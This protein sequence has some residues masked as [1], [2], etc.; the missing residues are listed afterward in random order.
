MGEG[1]QANIPA[2]RYLRFCWMGMASGLLEASAGVGS[3]GFGWISCG[4]V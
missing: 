4:C 3:V 2:L 1:K